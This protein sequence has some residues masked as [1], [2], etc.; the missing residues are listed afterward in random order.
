MPASK[1]RGLIAQLALS[2]E[3]FRQFRVKGA[4]AFIPAKY[5]HCETD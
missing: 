4:P 5:E 3:G 2:K 1:D